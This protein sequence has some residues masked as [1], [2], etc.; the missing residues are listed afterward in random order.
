MVRIHEFTDFASLSDALS[1]QW[2]D[3]I[4]EK[5]GSSFALAGG[6]TPAPIYRQLDALLAA[7]PT[8]AEKIKLVA[9]DERW[10]SDADPQSNEGLFRQC[11]ETSN[12]DVQHW[13]LVSLKTPDTTPAD[14]VPS[15]SNRLAQQLPAAF[16]AVLLGMG[17]DGH[18]ASLFPGAPHLLVNNPASLC[19]AA[20]NP[21]SGQERISLSLS[22]LL[23]AERI[24]LVITGR[25]KRQVLDSAD[26]NNLPVSTLLREATC[27]VDVF[28]SP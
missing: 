15:V 5:P 2:L 19:V 18:V 11:L 26:S 3:I 6:T 22:R 17:A 28:W 23:N 16:D 20:T 4:K 24:W 25:D 10:V 9:T 12:H 1:A 14:A 27:A 21:Q 7:S 8:P 13:Q